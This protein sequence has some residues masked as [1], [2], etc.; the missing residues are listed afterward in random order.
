MDKFSIPQYELY[1]SPKEPVE[2]KSLGTVGL[3]QI[4]AITPAFDPP[5]EH[6]FKFAIV[7]DKTMVLPLHKVAPDRALLF[8]VSVKGNDEA[9]REAL[10]TTIHNIGVLANIW[11]EPEE[12]IK[13]LYREA[14]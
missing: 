1:V 7:P 8:E 4:V 10:Q 9:S 3:S 14:Q 13:L 5:N 6:F 2:H 12:A 11:H